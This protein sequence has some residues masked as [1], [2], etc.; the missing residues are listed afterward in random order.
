MFISA[1]AIDFSICV[2]LIILSKIILYA[3]FHIKS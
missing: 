2:L 1:F 3:A